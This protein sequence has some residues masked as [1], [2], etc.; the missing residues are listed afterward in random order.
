MGIDPDFYRRS[1]IHVHLPEGAIPKDGPSA[2]V[3]IALAVVSALSGEP[4]RAGVAASGEITLR[5]NIL[6]VGGL[7]E[8][9]VAAR[10]AGIREIL[11]PGRNRPHFDELPPELRAGLV[12]RFVDSMDEVL[13]FGLAGRRAARRAAPLGK[14]GR[15]V[16]ARAA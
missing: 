16:L 2:G 1:D 11:L 9:V 7:A 5:G 14:R 15:Q 8:K 13:A 4:S 3:A 10:R 12:V 6:A